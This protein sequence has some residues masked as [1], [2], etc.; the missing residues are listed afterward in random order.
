MQRY[1]LVGV[2]GSPP[3]GTSLSPLASIRKK[4]VSTTDLVERQH[5]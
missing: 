3:F 2:N 5:F 1:Y 4:E